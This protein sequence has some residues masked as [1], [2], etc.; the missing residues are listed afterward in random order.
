MNHLRSTLLRSQLLRFGLVG[1]VGFLVDASLTLLFHQQLGLGE[2]PARVLAFLVAAT[3]GWWLNHQFTF[4]ARTPARA[5]S[6]LRYVV[7]TSAG[8]AINIGCYLAVVRVLGTRP[9]QLLAGVAVGSI[10][11]M[12]FNFWVSRRWVFAA[13]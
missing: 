2:A 13:G 6:W 7:L 1:C 11:A 4:Q 9:L 5:S 10:V 8:A 12:G 3:A